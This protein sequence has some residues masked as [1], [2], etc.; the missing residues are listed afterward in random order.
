MSDND[1]KAICEG[2]LTDA[3][4]HL[5]SKAIS[6][7]ELTEAML[8]RIAR[9]DPALH[10]YVTVTADIARRQARQAEQE[11]QAGRY[12]GPLHGIP[13]A[14][15]DLCSTKG[16]RTTCASRILGEWVP[17]HDATVVEKLAAAGA[18]MLG[19]LNMT[20]FAYGGYHPDLPVPVNPWA[21]DRW[22][23]AS[24]SGSGVATAAALCFASLGSD[25]G[26]SIRFPSASCGIVGVKPT[27][28]RVS[29][30]G[31]FPLAESLDH[32][33]PMTRSVADA[34]AVLAVISGFDPRDPTTRREPLPDCLAG[35]TT[36]LR[37]LTI[38]VDERYCTEGTD[39]EV[40]RA[41]L[42]TADVCREAGARL[43]PVDVTGI[44]AAAADWYAV[45]AVE[46]AAAHDAY[47]LARIDEYGP[48]FRSLL[49]DGVRISGR[50][51]A[52]AQFRRW[53]VC[54]IV[55]DLWQQVDLFLCPSMPMPPPSLAE[56][57][58]DSVLPAEAVAPLLRFTAPFDFTGSPTISVPC[59]FTASGLPLSLQIV[60]RHGDEA[61]V[62][63]AGHAFEQTTD[64]HRRRPTV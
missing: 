7:T 1:W 55:D 37:G 47:L 35:L 27:Y 2:T 4:H 6:P 43:R 57:R 39:P 13:V 36:D 12:R 53:G 59:G 10:G 61:T 25:T 34:A 41:V 45:C 51:Y 24:S 33:G 15:K 5:R 32:I 38:G 28:G 29:R 23:G 54:R 44:V 9:H 56:L 17:D 42:A 14:I 64:W 19:K 48:T 18:V 16:V 3:A 46:A 26:G 49:K 21:P 20:E 62:V 58:P 63:R 8:E 52:R 60:G 11:I 30:Y 40:T 31:V 22:P 50:D